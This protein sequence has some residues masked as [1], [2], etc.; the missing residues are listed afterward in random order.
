M[1]TNPRNVHFKDACSGK[2]RSYVVPCGKCAECRKKSQMEFQ[3]LAL[4]EALSSGIMHM[5]TL[6][7]RTDMCPIAISEKFASESPHII[8]FERGSFLWG[9]EKQY[10]NALRPMFEDNLGNSSYCCCSLHRE[11]VKNALKEFRRSEKELCRSLEDFRY[12][13]FGEYG[14]KKGRPHYH[15]ITFGLS[16]QQVLNFQ[17]IWNN[18]FGDATFGPELSKQLTLED[19]GRMSNY[20]SKYI[21]K[22]VSSRWNHILP[23]VEKPRRQSSLN[24]GNFTSSEVEKLRS[25]MAATWT[26][27]VLTLLSKWCLDGRPLN[28]MVIH[29]LSLYR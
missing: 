2:V 23:Y 12:A 27:K 8:G 17:R 22:G 21:S 18:R 1:C 9:V 24:F 14:D 26:K 15:M 28:L 3:A 29:F 20:V 25:M 19:I 5:W 6:T 10:K 11:D 13:C 16:N 4:H 7:Y